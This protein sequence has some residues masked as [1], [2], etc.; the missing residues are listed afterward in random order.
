MNQFLFVNACARSGSRTEQLARTVLA[1]LNRQV[2]EVNLDRRKLPP[3]GRDAL[4]RRESD[5]EKLLSDAQAAAR[6]APTQE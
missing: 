3:I 4:A 2:L 1:C 5:L 6:E